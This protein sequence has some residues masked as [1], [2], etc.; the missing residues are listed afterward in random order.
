MKL[1]YLLKISRPR[2]WI[3]LLGP[4][5][6]GIIAATDT[7]D[8]LYT[9]PFWIGFLY[10]LFPANLLI[11]GANDISDYQTDQHNQKKQ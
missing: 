6:I 10:F 4:Y 5:L 3:Y 7:V 8:I 2:F 9:I 1:S 11:Y